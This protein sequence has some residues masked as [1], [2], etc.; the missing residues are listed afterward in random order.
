MGTIKT[1]TTEYPLYLPYT[2][3]SKALNSAIETFVDHEL[4]ENAAIA[5]SLLD[6]IKELKIKQND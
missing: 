6:K 4:Y 5:K 3:Y 2:S 1:F